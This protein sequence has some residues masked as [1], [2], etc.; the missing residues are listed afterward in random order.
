MK[1]RLVS[2]SMMVAIV[3]VAIA[4][5]PPVVYQQD[6]YKYDRIVAQVDTLFNLTMADLYRSLYYNQNVEGGGIISPEQLAPFLDSMLIDT[7][8]GLKADETRLEDDYTEYRGYRLRYQR[9]LRESYLKYRIFDRVQADSAEV[10]EFYYSRPDL[11]QVPEQVLLWQILITSGGLRSG[12]D[13]ARY[14]AMSPAE[15]QEAAGQYA[16]EVR[17]LIDSAD[18]FEAIARAYSHETEVAKTG[19][20]VGWTPH[21]YYLEPFDSVAFSTPPGEVSDPYQDAD[22]WHI[23]YIEKYQPEGNPPLDSNQYQL[24]RQNLLTLK[25]NEINNHLL[26]SITSLP[27][28]VV[29]NEE[30]IDTNLHLVEPGVW[31][32]IVNKT[33]TIEFYDLR[34]LEERYRLDYH[35]DN[36]TV[37]MKRQMIQSFVNQV[38][39]TQT[40]RGDRIDTLPDVIE[41]EA[42]LRHE[43]SVNVARR[44]LR[45]QTW[46]PTDSM[47]ATYYD[48]HREEFAVYTPFTLRQIIVGDSSL[49]LF[50]RDQILSGQD[51]QKLTE[52]FHSVSSSDPMGR[53]DIG[54][55]AKDDILPA[56]WDQVMLTSAGDVTDP[57]K[58]EM[59]YHLVQVLERR[60]PKDLGH[61]YPGIR[62]RLKSEHARALVSEVKDQLYA[63]YRVSFKNKPAP[64]HLRPKVQRLMPL[65]DAQ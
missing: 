58:S 1:K 44:M 7:L 17:G 32:A 19:G 60:D 55:V 63:Q 20:K 3:M 39:L 45:D 15:L 49:G 38:L 23:L 42:S 34:G 11:H 46:E 57:I 22:A 14:A 64:I 2:L 43:H 54:A 12:P 36:T 41:M 65:H 27:L 37:E 28:E 8:I 5:R 30:I 53:S 16:F 25:A 52:Q 33:D 26:D 50:L 4:C 31:A 21:G 18:Q 59:G 6:Y 29:Y 48:S 13:S 56:I 61:A 51:F 47:I 35:I 24:A 62:T 10:A 40:A 9:F